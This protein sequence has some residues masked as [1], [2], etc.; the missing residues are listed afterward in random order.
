MVG[1]GEALVAQRHIGMGELV[2]GITFPPSASRG[3]QWRADIQGLRAVAVLAVVAFH[4]GLPLPGGFTGVDVFFVISGYVITEML[5]R[6]WR[7]TGSVRLG[8]FYIRRFRRLIPAL[9][10]L[11]SVTVIAAVVLLPPL[12]GENRVLLT[13][14]GAMTISANAVIVFLAGDYFAVDAQTNPLLHT[15]SLSVEEQ[16]YLVFP[17]LVIMGLLVWKGRSRGVKALM[18]LVTS[19]TIISFTAMM[20]A[21]YVD[22]PVGEALFGFYSPVARAWEF[23]VGALVSLVGPLWTRLAG[24][25]LSLLGWLG[26]GMIVTGFFGIDSSNTF[27]GLST[28]LPVVGTA[29]AIISG[30]TMTQSPVRNGLSWRPLVK[31]GDWSYSLYLWHWPAVVFASVLWPNLDWAITVAAL[32]S[33]IPAVLSYYLVERPLRA[34]GPPKRSG[35]VRAVVGTLVPTA[36]V[37]A[38]A[39]LVTTLFI[40]PFL[41]K[42]LGNPVEE[43]PAVV[44]NCLTD[45]THYSE[46]WAKGCTWFPEAEGAPIYLV[47]DSNAAHFDES[48]LAVARELNRPT[49]IM[50]GGSC[51][52][53]D[54]FKVLN[55]DGTSHHYWC[56]SYNAFLGS[57]LMGSE[58][59]TVVV[60]FSDIHSWYDDRFYSW[61]S[62]VPQEGS[63]AKAAVLER[64]LTATVRDLQT[65]GHEVLL[66]QA[67]PQFRTAG[68]FQPQNCTLFQ[69]TGGECGATNQLSE[70]RE[71]QGTNWRVMERVSQ[72]TT[73]GLLDLTDEWCS[74]GTCSATRGLY[75]AYR[76]EIHISAGEAR[77]LGPRFADFLSE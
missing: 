70:I 10:L 24:R 51:I 64:A 76:D 61:R 38:T 66:V 39:G 21:A 23:G 35:T 12:G 20:V 48:V 42:T 22:L 52:P 68:G 49:T 43:S 18:W 3:P 28:L 58:P 9:A 63:A 57:Y 32:V 54:D 40:T 77:R 41:V 6:E 27:P 37:L 73:A 53:I 36:A 14:I 25:F 46:R 59:G 75:I 5:V 31:I 69:L 33:I 62:G 19:L 4:G 30:F 45:A 67:V 26:V 11:V 47:G 65:A 50:A 55:P 74:N 7:Q 71:V 13:A 17:L 8:Q 60:G 16:F 15:W 72:K 29:L 34:K 56:P 2:V 44:T 1:T